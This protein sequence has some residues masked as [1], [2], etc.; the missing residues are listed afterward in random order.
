MR[1]KSKKGK[2]DMKKFFLIG[3]CVCAVVLGVVAPA[4]AVIDTT[5]VAVISADAGSW[6]AYGVTTFLSLLGAGLTIVA[7]AWVYR[8]IKHGIGA[9]C[10]LAGAGLAA[11]NANA[12]I[13][14]TELDAIT[15][16]ATAWI[17]YGVTTFLALLGAG[18][19]I[20]AGGWVYRKI[21]RAVNGA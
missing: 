7:G 9:A 21:K 18:L 16:D 2:N 20:V 11:S 3:V 19:T 8:K 13:V 1:S 4:Q 6:I 17:A 14:T 12:A 5:E 15:V 10:I